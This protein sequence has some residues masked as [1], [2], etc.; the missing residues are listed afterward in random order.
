MRNKL[1]FVTLI[2]IISLSTQVHKLTT[3]LNTV[4]P[5]NLIIKQRV[6]LKKPENKSKNPIG[7]FGILQPM[8]EEYILKHF[9]P[10]STCIGTICGMGHRTQYYY[11]QKQDRLRAKAFENSTT[12]MN[13]IKPELQLEYPYG[14]ALFFYFEGD[15]EY[16][17]AFSLVA[18]RHNCIEADAKSEI[19]LPE[20]EKAKK[21]RNIHT[22][23]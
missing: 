13:Y 10:D 17:H 19:R 8:N 9:I 5:G 23:L 20:F 4:R 3:Y 11:Y 18:K 12:L 1:T 14:Y 22:L 15:G 6:K 2:L 16:S 7:N 21:L